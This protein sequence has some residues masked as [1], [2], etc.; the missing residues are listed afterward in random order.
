MKKQEDAP[1]SRSWPVWT[2][3]Y[4]VRW[5]VEREDSTACHLYIQGKNWQGV[6]NQPSEVKDSYDVWLRG[7]GLAKYYHPERHKKIVRDFS[8]CPDTTLGYIKFANKYGPLGVKMTTDAP[9]TSQFREH[10]YPWLPEPLYSWT[11]A[12]ALLYN[13]V[14][15]WDL[16]VEL[17]GAQNRAA[18]RPIIEE[19]VEGWGF[20][21]LGASDYQRDS[22]VALVRN[23][24][25]FY[26]NLE[27][28]HLT[29]PYIDQN[30]GYI[31]L[32]PK[33]LLGT[34]YAMF[35]DEVLGYGR[36]PSPCLSCGRYF[37][38]P[39]RRRQYCSVRCR[40]RAHRARR[41]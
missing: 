32:Y 40:M 13:C 7:K 8:Y 24:T 36:P 3:G 25:I 35:A 2:Q 41:Q 12:R 31:R 11:L 15:P 16:A 10:P 17:A 4:E 38:P 37:S 23:R 28:A 27:L 26:V 39:T 30:K 34:M 33:S 1:Y 14:K 22:W 19:L 21:L 9:L 20:S 6:A 29:Q 18:A 5:I